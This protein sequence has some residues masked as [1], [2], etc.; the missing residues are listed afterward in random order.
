MLL[1]LQAHVVGER[2]GARHKVVPPAAQL[3]NVLAELVVSERDLAV[4]VGHHP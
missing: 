3:N 4:N 2:L 1:E